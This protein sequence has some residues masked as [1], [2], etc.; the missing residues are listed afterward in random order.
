MVTAAAIRDSA[1]S[2]W[3]GKLTGCRASSR[4][5]RSSCAASATARPIGSCTSTARRGADRRDR[6]GSAQAALAL[7]RAA[8]A[9][10]SARPDPPRGARRSAHRHRGA[11]GRRA[12]QPARRRGR[13]R[14][15]GARLRRG[16]APLRLRGA[17]PRRLQ[18]ALPLPG[19]P[20][21]VRVGRR[22]GQRRRRRR[23][24]H[25]ARLPAEAGAGDGLRARARLVRALRRGGR[26]GRLLGRCRR[27]GLRRLRA[28]GFPLSGEAHEFMVEALGTPARPGP[29]PASRARC[30]RPSA[31]SPRRSST[32]RT[33]SF[34]PPP[35]AAS[36]PRRPIAADDDRCPRRRRRPARRARRAAGHRRLEPA[37]RS[38]S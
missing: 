10:L 36:G 35:D 14:R 31:R 33:C 1:P 15:R 34:A 6:Q 27:R 22:A 18:P 28:R 2:A 11:H 29:A 30:A 20:R 16:A 32:T 23:P 26:A 9:V 25:G 12:P 13:A 38:R 8:G 3:S 37:R 5:R 24:G 19:D 4:P 7:R 17:E 21:R